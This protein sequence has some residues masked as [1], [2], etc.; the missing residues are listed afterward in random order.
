MLVEHPAI[1]QAAVVAQDHGQHDRR[2]VAFLV[3]A[4]ADATPRFMA[5]LRTGLHTALRRRLPAYMVPA[6]F[7]ILEHLS[8]TPN[9]KIDRQALAQLSTARQPIQPSP[10]AAGVGTARRSGPK[11]RTA[12]ERRI[13]DIWRDVLGPGAV[14]P[15]AV[16]IDDSFFELGG[17]SLLLAQVHTRL[18][19]WLGPA[20][21]LDMVELFRLPTIRALARHL[22]AVRRDEPDMATHAREHD[23]SVRGTGRSISPVRRRQVHGEA[24]AGGRDIAIVGMAGRFPGAPDVDTLWQRLRAGDELL[25]HFDEQTLLDAGV[26][27]EVLASPDY[28][29][30]GAQLDGADCFDAAFFG[31]SPRE[32]QIID[33]QQRIFLECAWTALESAGYDPTRYPDRIG[34]F[35][36]V[37][38]N[39]YLLNLLAQPDLI[40]VVGPFQIMISNDKDYLPTRVS[41]K[42]GLTGPGVAIQTA[43]STSLVAISF[44]CDAL[45][46]GRA[47]MV[48]AGGVTVHP[49]AIKPT[50][51]HYEAGGIQS[52]D[53]RTRSFDA[54]SKGTLASSAAGIVVLKRL[55]DA[56][57]DGDTIRA[58]IKGWAINN[59]GADKI[60]FTAPSV[61]GQAKVVSE[62]LAAAGVPPSSIGYVEAHG[63]GTP[64]GDPI[65]VAALN[66]AF[67]TGPWT[68]RSCALGSIK[69]NLGH[70]DAAAGVCGVIKT[71]LALEHGEIPPSLFFD[72]PNPQID[73]DAGPFFVADRLQP[74][75]LPETS[76]RNGDGNGDPPD[77]PPRAGVSALGIGG[78][79]AHIVLERAPR[80]SDHEASP[81]HD[82]EEPELLLWSAATASA[83]A[84]VTA[85]L[86]DYFAHQAD[87]PGTGSGSSESDGPGSG[88]PSFAA[89]AATLQTGRRAFAYRSFTVAAG[90]HD[91]AQA[92]AE[93]SRLVSR[94]ADADDR[95]VVF[96][97]PGGGAQHPNMGRGLY[98]QEPR[99]RQEIDRIATQLADHLGHD[100]RTVLYPGLIAD[101]ETTLEEATS[102]LRRPSYGL[103]ALFTTELALARLWQAWGVTPAAV[104]GHSLG[105]YTAAVI[106]GV[107]SA[108]EA[109]TLVAAR[110]V[111]FETL[112]KGAM[113]SVALGAD[114]LE[115][116]RRGHLRDGR[117]DDLAIAAAN[118][119]T[120][121]V[122]SGSVAAIDALDAQ[123]ERDGIDT[124]RLHIDV[125]AHSPMVDGILERFAHVT[126]SIEPR[127]PDLPLISN[128]TGGWLGDDAARDVGYWPCHLRASVRFAD[129]LATLLDADSPLGQPPV[130]LEVGPGHT[131]AT[132]A[133][134]HPAAARGDARDGAAD[135]G[136]AAGIVSSLRAPSRQATEAANDVRDL[137]DGLGRLWLAGVEI[138][139]QRFGARPR[140][141][142]NGS[143]RPPRRVPLPTYP[144]HARGIGSICPRA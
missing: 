10:N 124:T 61:S 32:A 29:R 114:V 76:D 33:P 75:P 57:A 89:A 56:L 136:G 86:G 72:T 125:A 112:P 106:A 83:R 49:T 18:R 62:A 60:G 64:L 36:G 141:P 71:V 127:P 1:R 43:C 109:V 20:T 135:T 85:N 129:G 44:A 70:T 94:S 80:S 4:H 78:T 101:D 90:W 134:Q 46:E 53:G 95:P 98:E 2:L 107:L 27:P 52:P 12:T 130:L 41:Y 105:E 14:G 137:L 48:L 54:R 87:A 99:F 121:S 133:R 59:D 120:L 104:I 69:S 77:T 17:H 16:G 39:G 58:V 142:A 113:L 122:A 92:L 30:V 21:P 47:E 34:V 22:D 81:Q 8:L 40:D 117:A 139:W 138:D 132:L 19:T 116:Y 15:D 11:P 82:L 110:G 38:M 9:A 5:E 102:L 93:P 131:L 103:P 115:R 24:E 140:S 143:T 96:L 100:P 63:T 51:Y 126:E 68:P 6:S 84:A 91:A 31:Y 50:G 13:A 88:G 26:S 79:N 35:G 7:E 123:L 25:T 118:T 73:F 74:W 111:L 65:E 23:G 119:P 55:D 128:V 67:T 45:L 3:V 28:I 108:E 37:G 66:R 144:S 42:L 97:F